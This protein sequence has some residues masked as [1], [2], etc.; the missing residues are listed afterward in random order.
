MPRTASG[1]PSARAGSRRATTPISFCSTPRIGAISPTTSAALSSRRRSA[2]AAGWPR[3]TRR[4]LLGRLPCRADRA[5]LPGGVAQLGDAADGGAA[6]DEDVRRLVGAVAR[7]GD[8]GSVRGPRG[9]DVVVRASCDAA[10]PGPVGAYGEDVS[11]GRTGF[12]AEG[13]AA[14]VGRPCG[15]VAAGAAGER[16]QARPVGGH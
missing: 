16:P 3:Q 10:Q 2:V 6:P 15:R 11:R 5:R 7:E 13:D 9:L 8:R 14:T 1:G 12:A 4:L